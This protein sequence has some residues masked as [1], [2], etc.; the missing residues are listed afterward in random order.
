MNYIAK[1]IGGE[2]TYIPKRPG[3]PDRSLADIEKIKKSLSWFPRVSIEMGVEIMLRRIND[4]KKAPVWT[5]STI[6]E[7]T[8]VWFKYLKE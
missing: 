6:K 7:A 4:W 8:K 2:I 3:E 5:K 1:L